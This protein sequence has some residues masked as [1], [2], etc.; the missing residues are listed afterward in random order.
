MGKAFT[1]LEVGS[2]GGVLTIT[3]DRPESLNA[4]NEQMS[5][6]LSAALRTAQRDENVRCIVLTGGGRAFCSGQ[7]LRDVRDRFAQVGQDRR[8][9]FGVLLRQ[10]YNPLVTRL[11]TL[12]KPVVAAV[13][14]PAAGAGVSLALAC[15]LRVC[16]RSAY[17]TTAFVNVG[18]IPDVGA[19]LTVLQ[20]VGYARAAELFYLGESLPAEEAL[21]YGLVNRVVDDEVLPATVKEIAGKLASMPTKAIGLIKRAL[22]RAWTTTLEEQLEYEAFLQS[23]AGKTADHHEGVLA[24]FE[25]RAADFK[26]K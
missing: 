16:V 18:L 19:T 12:E 23:T 13:N 11:R 14:G 20:H 17:F 1:T 9:D 24:F 8:L 25:K 3:L 7:D 10:Q 21:Q 15:D 5:I 4:L 26:G 22:N 2:A 6:E